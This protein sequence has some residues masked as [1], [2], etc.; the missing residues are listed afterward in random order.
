[1]NSFP[2]DLR[3]IAAGFS[4]FCLCFSHSPP[5]LADPAVDPALQP[6]TA[7]N[8]LMDVQP[9]DWAYQAVQ[10]L[11]ERYE[12]LAGYSG[13]RWGGKGALTR[14]A[15]AASLKICLE[16]IEQRHRF[17]TDLVQPDLPTLQALQ[18]EFSPELQQLAD[19]GA[20]LE[21]QAA[22]L[23]ERQ[24]STTTKLTGQLIFATNAGGFTGNT[25]LDPKGK[26]IAQADP[27][28]TSL[29]RI[30]L[31]LNTS[32]T[33]TDLLKVRLV[34][35]SG[36]GND[37]AA[38]I[39]EPFFGS[40][41][42]F[43][44][45]PPSFGTV[46]ITRLH[47]SFKPLPDL[48]VTIAPEMR[49]TDFVDLNRYANLGF[50]DFS[51]EALVNNYILFPLSGPTTGAVVVWNPGRRAVTLRAVY[52]AADAANPRDQGLL[53]GT[54][55]FVRLLYPP[56]G[57]PFTVDL[58]DRGLFGDTFQGLVE[59]EYAPARRFTLRLQ[60]SGG[61]LFNQRFDGVGVNAELAITEKIGLVGRYGYSHYENTQFGNLTPNYWMA[62]LVVRDIWLP[63]SLAGVGVSQPFITPRIGNATQTNIE[64]FYNLPLSQGIQIAP[65]VQVI[66][67]PGNQSANGTIFTGTLRTVFYF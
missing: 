33:G 3:A 22:S 20:G 6:I 34:A 53:R 25:I 32:F 58:G 41:L 65:V 8:Q 19:R 46:E 40:G 60:Y 49:V 29:Y 9:T 12:C 64:V 21:Q 47:Y 52:A 39:L 44:A 31:D 35:A 38:G 30:A 67:S 56:P 7:V 59:V 42:D 36:G 61:R 10:S 14:S 26:A 15:F 51:T 23:E 63:G 5:S 27:N 4:L 55:P 50:R 24:F 54:A 2:P 37:N 13:G 62:G 17:A 66:T 16:Q 18:D 57:N 48:T 45:K 43:S 1:M 28:P 11:S